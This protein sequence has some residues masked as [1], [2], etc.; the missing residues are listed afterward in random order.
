MHQ[1]WLDEWSYIRFLSNVFYFWKNVSNQSFYLFCKEQLPN[2][3]SP[4]SLTICENGSE[5]T[6]SVWNGKLDSK[7][8]VQTGSL[9]TQYIICYQN[10]LEILKQFIIRALTHNRANF[11]FIK[12]TTITYLI[13]FLNK[14][15]ENMIK[16]KFSILLHTNKNIKDKTVIL[17]ITLRVMSLS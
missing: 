17:F 13:V 5:Y 3:K 9:S 14:I 15:L 4:L 6:I 7:I 2:F 10:L 12:I 16:T 1:I 8:G 11:S